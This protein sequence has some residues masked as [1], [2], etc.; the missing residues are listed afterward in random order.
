MDTDGLG[1][2]KGAFRFTA[3]RVTGVWL[4]RD[5]CS[6]TELAGMGVECR[7]A[8]AVSFT[9][10]SLPVFTSTSKSAIFDQENEIQRFILA[11]SNLRI[12][13]LVLGLHLH[14]KLHRMSY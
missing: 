7:E 14:Q 3:R 9:F 2:G 10:S 8:I 11:L 1:S 4:A 6:G 13:R 12:F 5:V